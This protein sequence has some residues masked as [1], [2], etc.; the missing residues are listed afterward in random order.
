MIYFYKNMGVNLRRPVSGLVFFDVKFYGRNVW[1]G[2]GCVVDM[3]IF[4]RF[5][6]EFLDVVRWTSVEK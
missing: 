3:V 4:E 1:L 5:I 6:K 2:S